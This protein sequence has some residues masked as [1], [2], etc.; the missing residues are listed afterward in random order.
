VTAPAALFAG[1]LHD[2]A[3]FPPGDAPM[4]RALPE[5]RAHRAGPRAR[6]VG[7]FLVAAGRLPELRAALDAE[8]GGAPPLEVAVTVPAGARGDAGAVAAVRADP[9]LRLAG[10]EVPAGGGDPAAAVRRAADALTAALPEGARG[11]VE[12]PPGTDPRP[13]MADLRAAGHG[14]KVRTG[15]L[16]AAAFPTVQ[17][18][19]RVLAA[20]AASGTPLKCT[21]GLHHAVRHTDP[22]TGFDHHG[23]LNVLL[24]AR[25]AA[26]DPDP[27]AAAAALAERDAARLA[28]AAAAL[29]DAGARAARAVFT[30]FGTCSVAEPLADLAAL[31]LL[32]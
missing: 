26:A 3:L 4:A 20:A 6:W 19:A 12:L 5:H 24:A 23:F 10:G 9:R 32:R 16:T 13:L 31:G 11:H 17:E 21:A 29:D 8:H 2:A 30:G 28:R 7:P 27:G 14:A 25:A 15:G 18:L 1:L 22:A